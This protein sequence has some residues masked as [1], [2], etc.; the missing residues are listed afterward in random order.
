[1]FNFES[2]DNTSVVKQISIIEAVTNINTAIIENQLDIASTVDAYKNML[3]NVFTE[4]DNV[5]NEDAK[6]IL[7]KS[8]LDILIKTKDGLNSVKEN[9]V[10]LYASIQS[11]LNVL[12]NNGRS[13]ID[14]YE[15]A[16]KKVN[17]SKYTYTMPVYS[18]DKL[19]NNEM[20]QRVMDYLATIPS[21]NK[22]IFIDSN[23]YAN[24]IDNDF[25]NTHEI[26]NC[27][28]RAVV[29]VPK[30]INIE[31][32]FYGIMSSTICNKSTTLTNSF[33]PSFYSSVAALSDIDNYKVNIEFI[34][35]VLMSELQHISLWIDTILCKEDKYRDEFYDNIK[36]KVL[37]SRAFVIMTG[38]SF[39]CDVMQEKLRLAN[40]LN[41]LYLKII[42]DAYEKSTSSKVFEAPILE[43]YI[44][45]ENNFET[46]I[47]YPE[48]VFC[49]VY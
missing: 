9:I 13:I 26:V 37:S 12:G 46:Q 40:E 20:M 29:G 14:K 33:G 4:S 42:V 30:T 8:S 1:M 16:L 5:Y 47:L 22:E 3:S 17:V 24:K 2:S 34:M 44:P 48:C 39:I 38:I 23:L 49:G 21:L 28:M 41:A 10:S 43:T 36:A 27:I 18:M 35:N 25:K 11:N 15:P 6:E 19:A 31:N 45:S 32:A 7:R